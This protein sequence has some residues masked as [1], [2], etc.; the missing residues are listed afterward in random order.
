M[1][2]G[3]L[4]AMLEWQRHEALF[5]QRCWEKQR[6]LE[7]EAKARAD[8]WFEERREEALRHQLQDE[9]ACAQAQEER[10]W[11]DGPRAYC[12]KGLQ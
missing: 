12:R 4:A 3:H 2:A 5:L 7:L 11:E 9:L 10:I 6:Q 1:R 8:E